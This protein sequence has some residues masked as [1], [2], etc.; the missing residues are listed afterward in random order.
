MFAGSLGDKDRRWLPH[1]NTY[2]DLTESVEEQGCFFCT[3]FWDQFTDEFRTAISADVRASPVTVAMISEC[4]EEPE[5][6]EYML[7][8]GIRHSATNEDEA[9]SGHDVVAGSA[10]GFR[11]LPLYGRAFDYLYFSL[12]L[13]CII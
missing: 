7:H 12:W 13:I 3:Q 8:V 11:L 4:S 5:I 6:E 1:L 10:K 9:E 2:S